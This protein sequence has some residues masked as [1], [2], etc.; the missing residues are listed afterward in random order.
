MLLDRIEATFRAAGTFEAATAL[1]RD[2]CDRGR[3]PPGTT[4]TST[5]AIRIGCTWRWT[6]S[7]RAHRSRPR[8]S[9][10]P[11]PHSRPKAGATS[12]PRPARSL[13]VAIDALD[14]PAVR[15]FWQAVLRYATK[16]PPARHVVT[17]IPSASP[18]P[19]GSSRWT[20]PAPSA[21]ASTS[22]SPSPTTSPSER[23]AA[24]LAAGGRS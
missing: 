23:I 1:G 18:P 8:R 19:S 14:I 10:P 21:T 11:S 24:A 5:S 7:G 2:D 16:Q 4:P 12:E 13:E 6:T 22:T 3:A 17:S 9:P 15:P 20:R